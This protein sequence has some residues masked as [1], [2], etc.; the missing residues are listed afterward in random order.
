MWEGGN[1]G[2]WPLA[3]L[4][5]EVNMPTYGTRLAMACPVPHPGS[6]KRQPAHC[7]VRRGGHSPLC[8]KHEGR[9]QGQAEGQSERGQDQAGGAPWC[10]SLPAWSMSR[11]C[12]AGRGGVGRAHPPYQIVDLVVPPTGHKHHLAC[13]LRDLQR[14][15]AVLAAVQECGSSHVVGQAAMAIPQSF[16]L[17]WWEEEPL[18]PPADVDRPAEGAEDVGMERRPAREP[19]LVPCGLGKGFGSS[20]WAGHAQA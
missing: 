8:G 3:V 1:G 6:P 4:C 18:F 5:V 16:F 13:L 17:S 9:C 19:L 2:W 20:K 7:G 14:W 15:A 10:V 11:A 12:R